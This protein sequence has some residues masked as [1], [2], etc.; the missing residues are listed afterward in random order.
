MTVVCMCITPGN[1]IWAARV[2]FGVF[3]MESYGRGDGEGPDFTYDFRQ[4]TV[5]LE[6]VRIP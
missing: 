4:A 2:R 1:G 3:P 6:K 5:L